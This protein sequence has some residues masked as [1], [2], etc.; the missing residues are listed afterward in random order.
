MFLMKAET[1]EIVLNDFER[2]PSMRRSHSV[3]QELCNP[4]RLRGWLPS[5]YNLNWTSEVVHMVADVTIHKNRHSQP[6]FEIFARI[7][8]FSPI[9]IPRLLGTYK[10][11]EVLGLS[12]DS[13][14]RALISVQAERPLD[15]MAKLCGI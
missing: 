4:S 5:F 12:S 9:R 8:H 14:G 3:I 15:D 10:I 11:G 13:R 1:D 6:R 7:H 2:E